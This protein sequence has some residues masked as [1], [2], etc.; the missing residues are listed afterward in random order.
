MIIA[1]HHIPN[2]IH[3]AVL[4][5]CHLYQQIYYHKGIYNCHVLSCTQVR[6]EKKA[7]NLARA[8]KASRSAYVWAKCASV[9]GVTIYYIISLLPFC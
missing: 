9:A 7:G 5:F 2:S 6:S 4:I 1:T 8:H 3:Q